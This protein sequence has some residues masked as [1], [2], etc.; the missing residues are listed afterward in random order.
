MDRS[1]IAQL[2]TTFSRPEEIAR[3]IRDALITGDMPFVNVDWLSQVKGPQDL[4]MMT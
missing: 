4:L 2:D 1:R 3:N